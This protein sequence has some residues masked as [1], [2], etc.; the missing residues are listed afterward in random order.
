[1]AAYRQA[2]AIASCLLLCAVAY[3]G[4]QGRRLVWSGR[5]KNGFLSDLAQQN[6]A[7]PDECLLATERYDTVRI[8]ARYASR[9]HTLPSPYFSCLYMRRL[10]NGADPSARHI[11]LL[12]MQKVPGCRPEQHPP[13]TVASFDMSLVLQVVCEQIRHW[14]SGRWRL[15]SWRLACTSGSYM[16]WWAACLAVHVC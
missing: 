10:W 16:M 11:V 1:M 3:C 9:C 2:L 13:C 6:L 14:H 4:E 5:R 15:R 7:L 8:R 12:K